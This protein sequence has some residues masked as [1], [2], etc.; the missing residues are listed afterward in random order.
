M[1]VIDSLN[2]QRRYTIGGHEV[3]ARVLETTRAPSGA[4]EVL[5]QTGCTASDGKI[6]YQTNTITLTDFSGGPQLES[7]MQSCAAWLKRLLWDKPRILM[8]AAELRK[9]D[10]KYMNLTCAFNISRPHTCIHPD[11]VEAAGLPLVGQFVPPENRN[12][13]FPVHRAHFRFGN[14]EFDTDIVAA[15]VNAICT[16]GS[17]L[18]LQAVGE[19]NE[20]LYDLFLTDLVRALGNAA[21]SK[22]RTVLILGSYGEAGR[23]RLNL[24]R[25]ALQQLGLEGVVLD[26]FADIHQ[27]SLFEKM[28]MFGSLARFIV[29]DESSAS[30]HL[31]E[32]KACADIGFVTAILRSGGKPVTWMNA[33]IAAERTYMK[34]FAYADEP[35]LQARVQDAVAWAQAKV[36]ERAAYYNR[37]YPW[38]NP[39]V[40]LGGR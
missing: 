6:Q 2:W 13:S 3:S 33:D 15:N 7:F 32:L 14:R 27:Q 21:R 29:C 12:I 35:E 1:T 17:D 8:F 19:N 23:G 24:I 30:G 20:F 31:I 36:D 39:N 16:I 22:E 4:I 37:E 26:E 10:G 18:V 11:F 28:L 34:I 38:R 5:I 40:R 25:E 9:S